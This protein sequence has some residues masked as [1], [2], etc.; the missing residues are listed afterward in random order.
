MAGKN[1]GISPSKYLSEFLF[2]ATSRDMNVDGSSTPVAFIHTAA[3]KMILRS[4][5]L[6]IEDGSNFDFDSFGG[7]NELDNGVTIQVNNQVISTFKNNVG[8]EMESNFS[9]NTTYASLSRNLLLRFDY[10]ITIQK[11][12][13]IKSIVNDDLTSLSVLWNKIKA[14]LN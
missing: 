1:N 10:D 5:Y 9:R 14:E 7:I 2:N 8:M 4:F 3:S 12:D 13:I 11:G 6:Y